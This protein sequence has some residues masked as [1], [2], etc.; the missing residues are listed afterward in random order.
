MMILECISIDRMTVDQPALHSTKYKDPTG[1]E[2]LWEQADRTTRP[3]GGDVDAVGI[4][5]I[6][7]DKSYSSRSSLASEQK[8][9]TY[10]EAGINTVLLENP[11]VLLEKQFRPAVGKVCIEL[12]AGLVDPDESIETSA[13]RELREETGYVGEVTQTSQGSGP[14]MWNGTY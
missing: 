7:R 13:V 5:A 9:P 14:V 4:V 8:S 2:R 1:R 3:K 11:S 6:L 10:Q 12:P